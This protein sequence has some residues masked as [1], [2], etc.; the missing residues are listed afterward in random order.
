MTY[1]V[2]KDLESDEYL[3]LEPAIPVY[4]YVEED[5]EK[6]LRGWATNHKSQHHWDA[7]EIYH[8]VILDQWKQ[9]GFAGFTELLN[10]EDQA[11]DKEKK[12]EEQ[13]IAY[14]NQKTG[15]Y[16]T[17]RDSRG[18]YCTLPVYKDHYGNIIFCTC[19]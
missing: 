8:P 12:K 10:Q 4:K 18:N 1:K 19:R 17:K 11:L 2:S 14:P 7:R 5:E 9:E 13:P 16:C 15:G 6:D 3:S